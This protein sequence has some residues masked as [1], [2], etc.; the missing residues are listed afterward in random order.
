MSFPEMG[1]WGRAKGR[2]EREENQEFCFEHRS[3]MPTTHFCGAVEQAVGFY[4]RSGVEIKIGVKNM[5]PAL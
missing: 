2:F 5:A 4:K 1:R 3:D